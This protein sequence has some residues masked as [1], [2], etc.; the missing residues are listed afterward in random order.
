MDKSLCKI[1][2]QPTP[3][4]ADKSGTVTQW[5]S[6]CRCSQMKEEEELFLSLRLCT[7][8][9]KRINL[10]RHGSFTQWIFR[11]D[12]CSCDKPEFNCDKENLS[13]FQTHA[14]Q[15][16]DYPELQELASDF[17]VMR[18]KPIEELGKGASSTVFRSQDRKLNKVVAIKILTTMTAQ[19]IIAF[20]E[21]A[22]LIARLKHKNIIEVVDFSSTENGTPYLVLEYVSGVTLKDMTLERGALPC[23]ESI[24]LILQLC[25]AM[26]YAHQQGVY[27]RDLKPENILVTSDENKS[28]LI[29][30]ID[31]G[32]AAARQ[33]NAT[34]QGN[35]IVGTPIYMSPDQARGLA[36]DKSSDLYSAGCIL[37]ELL[38]AIPPFDGEEALEIIHKKLNEP[39]PA[40][41]GLNSGENIPVDLAKI[42]ARSLAPDREERYTDF[43][44][45][46]ADLEVCL[47]KLENEQREIPDSSPLKAKEK[48]SSFL[49]NTMLFPVLLLMAISIVAFYPIMMLLDGEK[50]KVRESEKNPKVTLAEFGGMPP[51][52]AT[53]E[54]AKFDN[55]GE[56]D[57]RSRED[58]NKIDAS[59][60][61]QIITISNDDN[62]DLQDLQVIAGHDNL[63]ELY[64]RKNGYKFK[65]LKH[66]ATLK[67]LNLLKLSGLALKD[68]Q[69]K[70]LEKCRSLKALF[71][72]D[73][74]M[75]PASAKFLKNIKNLELL[76]VDDH[77]LDT[78]EFKQLCKD[79]PD[80]EFAGERLMPAQNR[81]EDLLDQEEL[82]YQKI[83]ENKPIDL[84][85]VRTIPS[86]LRLFERENMLKLANLNFDSKD[87][88]K[89]KVSILEK[90]REIAIKAQGPD[91]NA[92]QR[93]QKEI[94]AQYY[95][96]GNYDT[97]LNTLKVIE[98]IASIENHSIQEIEAK[99][100]KSDIL[101]DTGKKNESLKL[102]EESVAMIK[103]IELNQRFMILDFFEKL[104]ARYAANKDW[105]AMDK[106]VER[107]VN[108]LDA[109]HRTSEVNYGLYL[110]WPLRVNA[111]RASQE[112]NQIERKERIEKVRALGNKIEAWFI[113]LGKSILFENQLHQQRI[114]EVYTESQVWLANFEPNL[115]KQRKHLEYAYSTIAKSKGL[116]TR[117]PI[118][119]FHCFSALGRLDRIDGEKKRAS[120]L[121]EKARKLLPKLPNDFRTKA[122]D[123]INYEEKVLKN[124]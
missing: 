49:S 47:N 15:E 86:A 82:K 79:L 56:Y 1:C 14:F 118:L 18:F 99:A 84:N 6:A 54:N 114:Y 64:I 73:C 103:N 68:D 25:D 2:L 98:Q 109:W 42:V 35:T 116:E 51:I 91:C 23:Q 24:E 37:Y 96:S 27:H 31:F 104:T 85:R 12:L 55:T 110:I 7:R 33:N 75:T 123:L 70:E 30:V 122:L 61:L 38:S 4:S 90:C 117:N 113:G 95:L 111:D 29:K 65:S 32:I 9:H 92:A 69:L 115:K 71:A 58:L 112:S 53:Q 81:F 121:F 66:I 13:D 39:V 89:K 26:I 43:K 40:L 87:T 83:V 97:A 80:C 52:A 46:K 102:L 105:K 106:A 94:A 60:T 28:I 100:L 36:F 22:K 34:Y 16:V 48:R 77:L 88:V 120:T 3:D 5:V 108:W 63:I 17:P 41:E 93:Y 10:V 78:P 45:L 11:T 50:E 67:N 72:S 59:K 21:E 57:L 19:S 101:W 119:C 20:Q 74:G 62:L 107:Q 76:T 8:C 44:E 124:G